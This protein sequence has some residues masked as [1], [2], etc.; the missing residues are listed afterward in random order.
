[1]GNVRYR[2]DCIVNLVALLSTVATSLRMRALVRVSYTL[3]AEFQT[4]CMVT[5]SALSG[6]LPAVLVHDQSAHGFR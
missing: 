5:V 1:M 6:E 2:V 4:P 3:L